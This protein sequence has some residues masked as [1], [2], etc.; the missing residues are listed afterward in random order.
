MSTK[1][2]NGST[3]DSMSG[4]VKKK[5]KTAAARTIAVQHTEGEEKGSSHA[6]PSRVVRFDCT[7]RLRCLSSTNI[8]SLCLTATRTLPGSLDV[9]KFSEVIPI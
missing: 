3:P 8:Y 9:E 4:R 5:L 2:K 1:R 7:F 6:G